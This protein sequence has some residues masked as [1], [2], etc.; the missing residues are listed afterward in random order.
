MKTYSVM[1]RLW[2]GGRRKGKLRGKGGRGGRR[3]G[4]ET[5]ELQAESENKKRDDC[6]REERNKKMRKERELTLRIM[7]AW[8]NS[9]LFPKMHSV[10]DVPK[11][12][13]HTL[14]TPR[15]RSETHTS[16]LGCTRRHIHCRRAADTH[17]FRLKTSCCLTLTTRHKLL[18][19]S[20]RERRNRGKKGGVGTKVAE[21]KS[22]VMMAWLTPNAA[23]MNTETSTRHHAWRT[24]RVHHDCTHSNHPPG[25]EQCTQIASH[26]ASARFR[27]C[28]YFFFWGG[29]GV[30]WFSCFLAFWIKG[31]ITFSS[32]SRDTSL[33]PQAYNK[34]LW[35]PSR[36]LS[37]AALSSS[38]KQG[39]H[40]SWHFQRCAGFHLTAAMSYRDYVYSKEERN[41]AA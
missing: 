6:K 1:F 24:T 27:S 7:L 9:Y 34:T 13:K 39:R 31:V 38:L 26:T 21:A 16:P 30:G 22:S 8:L 37:N 32:M 2:R 25:L 5:N 10:W 23:S 19:F 12:R 20:W 33:G 41:C 3:D 28:Y 40:E 4:E 35:K 36:I 17:R 11:N 29:G 14:H 15:A 18:T